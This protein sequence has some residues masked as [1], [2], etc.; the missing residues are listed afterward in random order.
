[1]HYRDSKRRRERERTESIFKAMMAEKFPN[2]GR[3]KQT[4]KSVRHKEHQLG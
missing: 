2:L 4:S 1:M 3:E